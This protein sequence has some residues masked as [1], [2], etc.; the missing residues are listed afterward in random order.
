M[1]EPQ[2][3]IKVSLPL[4]PFKHPFKIR[5]CK[6]VPII[7]RS[8]PLL[9]HIAGNVEIRRRTSSD[10]SNGTIGI[11][12]KDFGMSPYIGAVMSAVYGNIA[13]DCDAGL[14]CILFQSAPLFF[15][16]ILQKDGK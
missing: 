14:R 12:T 3:I 16:N 13:D 7:Y 15:K 2:H 11:D 6:I 1:I 9:P 10:K 8:T 4:K 5:F